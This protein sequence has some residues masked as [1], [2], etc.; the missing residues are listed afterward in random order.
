METRY[1][2]C[3][4]EEYPERT[5]RCVDCHR[6]GCKERCMIQI[7]NEKIGVTQNL[8][9]ECNGRREEEENRIQDKKNRELGIFVLKA[10]L[11]C[12]LIAIAYWVIM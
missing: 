7:H 2:Q 5:F 4:G 10:T 1:C 12:I 11:V 8:C 3:C 9:K 6:I